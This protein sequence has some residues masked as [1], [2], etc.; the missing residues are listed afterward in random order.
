MIEKLIDLSK[1]FSSE[2]LIQYYEAM[3]ERPD[4]TAVLKSF[5]NP[6]FLSLA[7]MIMLFRLNIL[8]Q[9]HLPAISYFTILQNSG[10]MG[11]WEEKDKSTELLEN[12]LICH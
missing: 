7:N 1:D 2:R 9:C 6:F 8:E 10:H 3:I 12:F 5:Q 11:M 4:R